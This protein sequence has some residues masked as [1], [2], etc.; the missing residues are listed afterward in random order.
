MF[1][2]AT[3]SILF[4]NLFVINSEELKA[5]N[6]D[7]A[8]ETNISHENVRRTGRDEKS[9]MVQHCALQLSLRSSTLTNAPIQG[10]H[11]WGAESM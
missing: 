8:V 10:T 2:L 11:G 4:E 9:K 5:G 3:S 6:D 1:Q 7:C